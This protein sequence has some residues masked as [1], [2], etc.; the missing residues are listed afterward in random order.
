MTEMRNPAGQKFSIEASEVYTLLKKGW[1]TTQ[2][3]ITLIVRKKDKT[4]KTLQNKNR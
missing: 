4:S 1:T 2:P 3:I